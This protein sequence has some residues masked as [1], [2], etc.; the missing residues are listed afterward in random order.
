MA[1]NIYININ[2]QSPRDAFVLSEVFPVPIEMFVL[3]LGDQPAFNIYLV[4]G[5]GA[6]DAT[7]GLAGYSL[8]MA[9][10]LLGQTEAAFQNSFTTIANG[11]TGSIALN[12]SGMSELLNSADSIRVFLE[13]EVTDPSGNRRTYGQ[14]DIEIRNQ[15]ISAASVV[16]TPTPQFFTQNETFDR[17]VQNRSAITGLIGGGVT[18]LDGIATVELSVGQMVAVVISSTL[19]VYQLASSTSAENVPTVVRP[20]DYAGGSNQKVWLLKLSAPFTKQF[21]VASSTWT[22]NHGLGFKPMVEAYNAAFEKLLVYVRHTDDNNLE[23]VHLYNE[24]GWLF[25]R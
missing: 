23:A 10:G 4:D 18:N 6:F 19:Y 13:I 25:I 22:W 14:Q 17:F 2:A 16:P 11:W 20:D 1:Q 24:S 5:A 8:R 15:V 3:V 12:T 9:V 7:S 21:S